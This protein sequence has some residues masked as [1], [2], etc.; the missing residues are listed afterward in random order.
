[1]TELSDSTEVKVVVLTLP[2]ASDRQARI[3]KLLDDAGIEF[4]FS[5]GVDGRK[6]HDPCMDMYDE[7]KRLRT[8]GSPMSPGQLGCY[9]G[10]Y[11]IWRSCAEENR[12]YIVLEDDVVFDQAG[13]ASFL[14]AVPKLPAR[15]ECLR[16]FKNKTRNHKEYEI[17]ETGGFKVLR[18]TKG[19]MSSM[20][21][22]LTPGAARK[23]LDSAD[24]IFLPVDIYMD[25]YWVNNVVCLGVSPAFISHDYHFDSMIGYEPK[26]GRRPLFI[27]LSREFFTLTERLR[28]FLFN[29]SLSRP[30][31][32]KKV[33]HHG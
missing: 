32:S 4:E 17:A 1:M 2:N 16:L 23:F 12:K 22:F 13:L 31:R 21:Y 9:A 33:T 15:F 18:Y 30:F 20:G 11:N 25:R 19:P 10:H 5:W 28:R 6:E 29:L 24:P 7:P 27:R 3:K 26:S 8:K 14:K